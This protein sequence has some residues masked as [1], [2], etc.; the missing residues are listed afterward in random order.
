MNTY[1]EK[2]LKGLIDAFSPMIS[3]EE[4]SSAYFV[5]RKDA[6]AAGL[7]LCNKL[8]ASTDLYR[9]CVPE[10]DDVT[11]NLPSKSSS[12][13]IPLKPSQTNG[14]SKS[15]K[16]KLPP[17]SLGTV[18]N[19]LGKD[20]VSIKPSESGFY[21]ATKPLKLDPE[22]LPMSELLVGKD[23]METK[24]NQMHKEM[25]D[26]LFKMLGEGF[27]LDRHVI[28]DVLGK[29]GYNMQEGMER[30]FYHSTSNL[31]RRKILQKESSL[32]YK[33]SYSMAGV[34]LQQKKIQHTER[35][36]GIHRDS[37]K[38]DEEFRRK[39]YRKNQEKE[40]LASLF[41]STGKLEDLMSTAAE[42]YEAPS[43]VV[44]SAEKLAESTE[45]LTLVDE[46]NMADSK[47][48]KHEYEEGS[49]QALRKAVLE[50]RETMK[51]YYAAVS[52]LLRISFTIC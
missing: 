44:E 35:S 3:P 20:Y 12:H 6:D 14:N 9:C 41:S 45:K 31:E 47:L 43:L 38:D 39:L 25:E 52:S 33:D 36:S 27:K 19:F 4:I 18:S 13:D 21:E 37:S 50:Y 49:Y 17:A 46:S 22:F 42:K 40:V 7:L 48:E 1:E 24:S 5:A 8:G 11:D 2:A 15:S 51:E 23:P 16:L 32:K 34:G 28:Q 26:F 30:L 29:C 10:G